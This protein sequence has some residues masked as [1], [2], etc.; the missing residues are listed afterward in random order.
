MVRH[1]LLCVLVA[2]SMSLPLT[3]Q[4]GRSVAVSIQPAAAVE[5]ILFAAGAGG[6]LLTTTDTNS[7][8]TLDIRLY[9]TCSAAMAVYVDFVKLWVAR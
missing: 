2:A 4:G 8:G 7:A 6:K 9:A 1:S 5:V 3:G